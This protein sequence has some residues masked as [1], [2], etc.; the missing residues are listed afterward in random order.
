MAASS[1]HTLYREVGILQLD[2]Y[3]W[4]SIKFMSLTVTTFQPWKVAV[5]RDLP[6]TRFTHINFFD[7]LVN[8][9]CT[10]LHF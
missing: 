10:K 8:K 1:H 6:M 4:T 2:S 7:P 3:P 9:I 5:W